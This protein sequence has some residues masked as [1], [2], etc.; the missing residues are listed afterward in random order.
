MGGE[1]V[2]HDQRRVH[3][4]HNDMQ[5]QT[6]ENWAVPLRYKLVKVIGSGSYGKVCHAVDQETGQNVAIKKIKRI[7]EDLIDCKRLLREIA[8][9]SFLNDD[10][11]VKLYDVCV[12][13]DP[14]NFTELYL[15]L[16][17]CDSD[18]KKLFKLP[19]YLSENH[20]ITL[21]FNTLCGLKYIHSA[22]IYHRD[23]KPANCLVNRDCAVKICDFGLSRPVVDPENDLLSTMENGCYI[24]SQPSSEMISEGRRLTGHVVTR[25]YR[26]PELI[27]LQENY[28]EQIDMWSLGCIFAE[29]LGMIKENYPNTKDRCPLFQGNTCYP[30]S[31]HKE[32]DKEYQYYYNRQSRDQLN[33]IFNVLGTPS[34]HAIEKLDKIDAKRYVRCF[35]ERPR[36]NW[37]DMSRFAGSSPEA[38]DLLDKM[39]VLDASERIDVDNALLH[40]LFRQLYQ[41]NKV[42]IA[43]SKIIL[44]FENLPHL[45]EAQLRYYF[46][47][48]VQRFHPE[49][50]IPEE[51]LNCV[52]HQ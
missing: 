28:T 48:E 35:R 17:L 34:E 11:V 9:L 16:E 31:P 6:A 5:S 14:R 3:Y 1:Q 7:F 4:S 45:G 24:N 26:A 43:P 30:L 25:W 23:L 39:L 22:G 38:L 15:V 44:D 8:I 52:P 27:L 32:H 47:V 46:L 19:E 37:D 12:P 29:L 50:V 33:V 51:L 42:K 18:F 41:P 10:R 2:Q 21:L 20:V 49:L 13:E 36:V 40:P